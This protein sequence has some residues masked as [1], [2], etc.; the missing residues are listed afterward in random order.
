MENLI[1]QLNKAQTLEQLD[2]A[3][4]EAIKHIDAKKV[5]VEQ[6]DLLSKVSA[7][8]VAYFKS[9]LLTVKLKYRLLLSRELEIIGGL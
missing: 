1:N 2:I 8:R 6:M 4:E 7:K 5:N 3:I 9:R